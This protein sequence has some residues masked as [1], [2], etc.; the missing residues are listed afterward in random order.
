MIDLHS[1]LLP[2][3]DDGAGSIDASVAIAR[4][5]LR[6]GIDL[7]AA[8]PHVRDDY[9]T[10]AA[11]ME[12]AVAEVRAALAAEGV[13]IELR[14]GGEVALGR[15]DQLDN[16]ELRRLGLAGRPDY[17]LIESPYYGWPLDLGE[18]VFQLGLRGITPVLAH[19]ERNADVQAQP[20]RLEPLVAAGMLVQLTA[21]SLDG[22]LG[23]GAQT[24][25]FALLDRG[26][27]HLVASDAHEPAVREIGLS[28]VAGAV[29]DTM[30]R[31]LTHDVPAAIVG[32]TPIPMRPAR[33]QGRRWWQRR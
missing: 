4:A 25:S 7:I 26:L 32:G 10:T 23:R 20:Q 14:T 22:R 31:W 12:G 15:L 30:A 8:T 11:E 3:L 18:R 33:G 13:E 19:P 2:G 5:A 29:G 21:A 24:G 27:A 1:H 6:D 17:L 9:P 16:D 28:S